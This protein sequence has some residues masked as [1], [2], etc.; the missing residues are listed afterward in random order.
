MTRVASITLAMAGSAISVLPANAADERQAPANAKFQQLDR[1]GD[2]YIDRS[3]TS[4]L[5]GYESAFDQADENR[6]GRLNADE[7]LKA[8]AIYDRARAGA[9]VEDG[10]LTTKVKT[11]LLRERN[12]KSN[13]VHVETSNGRV[14][15]SGWVDNR[16]QKD[17]AVKVA[18]LV[19]G[20]VEVRDALEVR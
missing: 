7:F 17:K 13:D 1:N 14:L 6:D 9:Y 18:S 11:A 16:E 3:E 15:L 2:G 4:Q 19:P 20:V 12:L 10:V 8:E 5:R